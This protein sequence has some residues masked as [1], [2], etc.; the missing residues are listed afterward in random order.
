MILMEV[1]SLDSPIKFISSIRNQAFPNDHQEEPL[2]E[3]DLL[4]R[5]IIRDNPPKE[6][7]ER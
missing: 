5:P 1:R 2:S 6:S 3:L 4:L 7:T